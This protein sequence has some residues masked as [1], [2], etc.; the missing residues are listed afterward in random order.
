MT[1]PATLTARV[2]ANGGVDCAV[3]QFSVPWW[4]FTKT[5]L[6]AAALQL[7]ARGHGS[8]DNEFDGR[9]FT[10]R[11]L[12]QHRAGLPDYG[13]LA[14][15]QEAARSGARPWDTDDLLQRA[16]HD[17]LIHAP[18][19]GWHYSN[20]GYLFVRRFIE[21]SSGTDLGQA[22]RELVFDR[23]GL[24]SVRVATDPRD[25]DAT[26]WGNSARYDPRWVYHGLIVG[27]P[28]DAAR[29]LHHLMTGSVLPPGL[30][31]EMT[32]PC[33]I[34]ASA[35]PE[36]PWLA[37]GYGL[38]LMIGPWRDTGAAIGHSGAGPGSVSAVYHFP[39]RPVPC[40]TAGFAMGE[41]EGIAENAVARMARR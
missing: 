25:L 23:I 13:T 6:A 27:S 4:S 5:A 30:L 9:P 33:S 26:A 20:I 32:T 2:D 18:G 21:R 12:L 7:V 1:R 16:G 17:R 10:L 19:H 8:L 14:G 28:A 31:K 38:G 39:D 34:G 41:L 11:Q 22:L 24:K 29:F 3:D 37:A 36:R 40:T 35:M 15:Y